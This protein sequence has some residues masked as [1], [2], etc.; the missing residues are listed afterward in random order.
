MKAKAEKKSIPTNVAIDKKGNMTTDPEKAAYG[1]TLPFD[2]SYKGSGL[3][4]IIEILAS[5]WTGAS[6]VNLNY[7]K[8]GWGNLYMALTPNLLSDGETFKKRIQELI[9]ILKTSPTKDDKAIRI[10]GE[11]TFRILEENRK[12]GEIEVNESIIKTIKEYFK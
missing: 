12:K 11:N 2:N 9:T 6:F 3:A 8:D 7:E 5:V 1:S 10:P 4:M